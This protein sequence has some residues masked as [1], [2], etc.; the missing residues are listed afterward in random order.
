M[1]VSASLL[2][3]AALT[4]ALAVPSVARADN[5]EEEVAAPRP[6]EANTKL[7]A[8]GLVFAGAYGASVGLALWAREEKADASELV[9]PVVGPLVGI[10]N[11]ES[12]IQHCY[13]RNGSMCGLERMGSLFAYPFLA[14]DA[15]AQGGGLGYFIAGLVGSS[16]PDSTKRPSAAA[17]PAKH[18]QVTPYTTGTTFGLTGSF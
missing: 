18:P 4:I 6:R 17:S 10:V 8:G 1:N 5:P 3:L 13:K 15:I 16:A 12:N 14:F 2:G 11:I 9:I 7:L